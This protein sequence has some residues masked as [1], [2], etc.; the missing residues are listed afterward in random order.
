MKKNEKGFSV[1]EV[2]IV[3]LVVVLVG[4]L[5]WYVWSK[6]STK[7]NSAPSSTSKT[8]DNTQTNQENKQVDVSRQGKQ[9]DN[10]RFA[11][12]LPEGWDL[13]KKEGDLKN[14]EDEYYTFKNGDDY[15]K[16]NLVKYGKDSAQDIAWRYELTEERTVVLQDSPTEIC[17]A[18][19]DEAGFCREG[20]EALG[21]FIRPAQSI[22]FNGVSETIYVSFYAG[23]S[24]SEDPTKAKL[25]DIKSMLNS[26]QFKD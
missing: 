13:E 18:S 26:I 12:N 8:S 21:I 11:M 25:E 6:N 9:V 19:E 5:G 14:P 2:F 22:K 20:D 17:D 15:L 7:D 1:V 16:I 10:D 24:A 3:V 4:F 23:N